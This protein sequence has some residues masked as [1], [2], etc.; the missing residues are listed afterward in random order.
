MDNENKNVVEDGVT[1]DSTTSEKVNRIDFNYR[2]KHYCLEYSREALVRMESAGYNP[3][4]AGERPMLELT[5][6]WAGAFYKNHRNES[7]KTIERILNEIPNQD[8]L[9]DSLREMV[10]ATYETLRNGEGNLK[11]TAS[12]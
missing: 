11:W 5:Q 12:A 3:S 2:G 4:E 6:L 1:E 10:A 9:L 8:E 7:S